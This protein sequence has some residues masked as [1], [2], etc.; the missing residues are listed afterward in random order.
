MSTQY[1]LAFTL[2]GHSEDVRNIAAPNPEVPMLLSASRDGSAIVWG[3]SASGTDWDAKLRV[4]ELERRY[5]S[6][7]TLVKWHGEGKRHSC[8]LTHPAYLVIGSA[9][10]LLSSYTLPSLTS[11]PPA[12]DAPSQQPQHTLA[13]HTL[14]LCCIDASPGGLLATGSW[15]KTA[16]IW[17]DFKKAVVI[18]G[19]TQAVWAVRFVGDDRV[20]T[21]R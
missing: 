19:H 1:Q 7:C 10:G 12:I 5:V 8:A 9:S 4:E 11:Q 18:E 16:I 13:E 3:P 21:G 15:D 2:H 20:I 14:N 17:K 6:C